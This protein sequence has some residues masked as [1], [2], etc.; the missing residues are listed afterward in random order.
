MEEYKVLTAID[1]DFKSQIMN[2]LC[3]T[4]NTIGELGWI[5]NEAICALVAGVLDA[6]A[7]INLKG[8]VIRTIFV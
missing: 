4:R 8:L 1:P 2:L 5:R 3:N 6:P 7:V